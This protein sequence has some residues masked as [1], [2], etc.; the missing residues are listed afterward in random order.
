MTPARTPWPER[1]G[2]GVRRSWR[3]AI[4]SPPIT[5]LETGRP[6]N[7]AGIPRAGHARSRTVSSLF[8]QRPGSRPSQ[9]RHSQLAWAKPDRDLMTTSP[10]RRSARASASIHS[11]TDARFGG[12]FAWL[13]SIPET[14]THTKRGK[15]TGSQDPG[16]ITVHWPTSLSSLSTRPTAEGIL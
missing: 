2:P 10:A 1:L 14:M 15:P 11:Q 7:Q 8:Q 16:G 5:R 6:A 3:A 4:C 9:H 12:D 13:T